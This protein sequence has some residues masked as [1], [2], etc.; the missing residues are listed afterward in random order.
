MVN[1]VYENLDFSS[2]VGWHYKHKINKIDK[3]SSSSR[4]C[5]IL[6]SSSFLAFMLLSTTSNISFLEHL[7]FSIPQGINM[8][9]IIITFNHILSTC[10]SR[11][12]QMWR[13][14]TTKP[15]EKLKI[16]AVANIEAN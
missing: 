13:I 14:A 16:R 12:Q 9:K 4:K 15:V 6:K 2:K 5:Q 8:D 7:L 11:A 1:Q 3:H 10:K